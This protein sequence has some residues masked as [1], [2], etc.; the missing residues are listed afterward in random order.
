MPTSPSLTLGG[1]VVLGAGALFLISSLLPWYS[2]SIKFLGQS[3]SDSAN[4]WHFSLPKIAALLVIVV[5]AEVIVTQVA[6]VKLPATV[7]PSTWNLGRLGLSGLAALLILIELIKGQNSGVE[8][9]KDA[10]GVLAG[11]GSSD[12]GLDLHVG[13]GIGM[14][15]GVICVLAL[16][17]GNFLRLKE[18]PAQVTPGGQSQTPWTP[19]PQPGQFTQPT[20]P[21]QPG[22]FNQADG[23]QYGTPNQPNQYGQPGE[24]QQPPYQP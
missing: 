1:K 17:A 3:Q 12:L 4:A 11:L 7:A 16:V 6:N 15:L 9:A 20:Q 19:Q 8:D 14:F 5:L 13:R 21:T 10:A 2:V 23:P 22:Q 24:G 18:T